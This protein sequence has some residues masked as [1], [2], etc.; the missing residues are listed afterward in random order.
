LKKDFGIKLEYFSSTK[1][2][3]P[4]FRIYGLKQ[5]GVNCL[6]GVFENFFKKHQ[7]SD[8]EPFKKHTTFGKPHQEY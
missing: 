6:K 7:S 5:E 1:L 4:I 3:M 2:L 8:L